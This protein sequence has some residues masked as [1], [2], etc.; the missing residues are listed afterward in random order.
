MSKRKNVLRDQ[1]KVDA[2][3]AAVGAGTETEAVDAALDLAVFRAEV[4][5]ALDRL[6]AVGGL[7]SIERVRRAV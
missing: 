4:F 7:A 1:R 2:A 5:R 3:K 6:V